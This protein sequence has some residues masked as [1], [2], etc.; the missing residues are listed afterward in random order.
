MLNRNMDGKPA[1]NNGTQLR[2]QSQGDTWETALNA[3]L[4]RQKVRLSQKKSKNDRKSID[5]LNDDEMSLRVGLALVN[6]LATTLH[7][8]VGKMNPEPGCVG[9]I[10]A[11]LSQK[12]TSLLISVPK[13]LI[14]EG[15]A[16]TPDEAEILKRGS[17]GVE[18]VYFPEKLRMKL[19]PKE[20]SAAALDEADRKHPLQVDE[21][22]SSRGRPCRPVLRTPA[23]FTPNLRMGKVVIERVSC[24]IGPKF[25]RAW[26]VAPDQDSHLDAWIYGL[27]VLLNM[28][29]G[30]AYLGTYLR[31]GG[32]ISFLKQLVRTEYERFCKGFVAARLPEDGELLSAKMKGRDSSENLDMAWEVYAEERLKVAGFA[33]TWERAYI[34]LDEFELALGSMS[35]FHFGARW[36]CFS[37]D[38]QI[39]LDWWHL[40]LHIY[41]GCKEVR[42]SES[43]FSEDGPEDGPEDEAMV[44]SVTE[45]VSEVTVD[46]HQPVGI[47]RGMLPALGKLPALD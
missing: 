33:D 39:P 23:S 4:R 2:F 37:K 26:Q 11:L 43:I 45:A 24:L 40:R 7:D 10:P 38:E 13:P 16:L 17:D 15:I 34:E 27:L 41:C 8:R 22:K 21:A 32:C 42:R 12:D 6:E 19:P 44:N 35:V 18:G 28:T 25:S 30:K 3:Y 36:P 5:Q 14:S 29:R 9:A 46:L 20:S 1:A 31:S 47:W